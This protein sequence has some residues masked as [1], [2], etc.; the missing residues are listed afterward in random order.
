[1]TSCC[2]VAG[3]PFHRQR[4]SSTCL[5]GEVVNA[6]KKR[7]VVWKPRSDQKTTS[8]FRRISN[9]F[10]KNLY[11][12]CDQIKYLILFYIIF[13]IMHLAVV[14][15][16]FYLQS[17]SHLM[18][19]QPGTRRVSSTSRTP[20]ISRLD[21]SPAP[22]PARCQKARRWDAVAWRQS[23]QKSPVFKRTSCGGAV[24]GGGFFGK[25]YLIIQPSNLGKP[26]ENP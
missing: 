13:I 5:E 15:H 17:Q 24:G 25:G 9:F 18:D 21:A 20:Q 16:I 6:Y 11:V 12:R 19:T 23:W 3:L 22:R 4:T 7:E 1:M 2:G 14:I 10:N 26:K 8:M